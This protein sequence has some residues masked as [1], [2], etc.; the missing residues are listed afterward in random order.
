MSLNAIIKKTSK[1][2]GTGKTPES[3]I[4]TSLRSAKSAVKAAGGKSKIIVAR[5]LPVL[6][7]VEGFLP[8]VPL[9][10]GALA[11]GAAEVYKAINV[12]K[13]AQQQLDESKRHNKTIEEITL[14]KGLYLKPYKSGLG[15]HLK[16]Y[17]GLGLKKG[18]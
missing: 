7:K 8:L 1:S 11:G 13:S 5:I 6:S 4:K 12:A 14:G 15:L 3:I 16:P 2:V 9:F 17:G 18:K 10:A